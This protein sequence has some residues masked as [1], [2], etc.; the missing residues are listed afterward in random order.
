[1]GLN[2]EATSRVGIGQV[3]TLERRKQDFLVN[4]ST[5]CVGLYSGEIALYM[6]SKLALISQSLQ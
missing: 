2:L 4:H 1:M 3:E 6:Y 5:G